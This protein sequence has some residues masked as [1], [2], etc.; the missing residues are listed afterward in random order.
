MKIIA[1]LHI[2]SKF[3]RA[4]S[5]EMDIPNI[6][7]WAKIKGINLIGTGDFTHPLWL[8]ELKG[9]LKPL[10]YGIYEHDGVYFF[11]S[12]EVNNIYFKN[13]Q[14]RKIH[15]IILAPDFK[16]VEKINSK[17]TAYG[18]LYSDGRPILSLDSQDLTKI[19][20]DINPNCL[21]IP[22]HIWTPHFSLFGENSG[23][24]SIEECFDK[25]TKNIYALETGLSSDPAM[26]WRLS[27]LDRFTLVSNS[28]AH[29]V[30]RLGREV[31]VFDVNDY[32]DL[33]KEITEII[34]TKDRKKFLYTIE[35][36]PE[37][38]KYHYDGHRNC[39]LRM[40]P[41]EALA[42]NDLCK[43]CNRKVTVG[44]L[45]RVEELADRAED[46]IP[47]NAIPFKNLI[48]L[49]EIIASAL[50]V[51]RSSQMV[52]FEYKKLVNHFGNEFE[53]LLESKIEDLEKITQ[54]KVALG[55]I[56]VREG[57][58]LVNPG[59]DGVYGEI[60]ILFE[61]EIKREETE[62]LSLF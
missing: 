37:E 15:N 34:R 50:N 18:E 11:L 4:T 36:F 62:Q 35:F 46:Y 47:T 3:S 30:Q 32:R 61:E 60:K 5:R 27:S 38:G 39:K 2:H 53:V 48:P 13:G 21:I 42:N 6:A 26:N 9:Y 33:Y 40:H 54:P 22:A 29:S 1:D 7:Q 51:T 16:T 55:I 25:D 31:N 56:K 41:R 58:V 57:K 45:H 12:G 24:N 19:V 20:L 49:E 17:L 28:D 23:F 8:S 44:V 52:N 14:T 10:H 59:Y 43:I